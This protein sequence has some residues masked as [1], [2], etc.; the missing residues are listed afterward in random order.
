MRVFIAALAAV[1]GSLALQMS[2]D[3]GYARQFI[4]LIPW[5]W[6]GCA[7]LWTLWLV[8]HDKVAKEWLKNLHDR[9]GKGVYPIRALLCLVVFVGVALVV[10]HWTNKKVES[11]FASGQSSPAQQQP[12]SG[13]QS[14]TVQ[15]NGN[16]TGNVNQGGNNNTAIIG[17]DNAITTYKVTG[18]KLSDW[19]V[20]GKESTPTQRPGCRRPTF[21]YVT[22]LYGDSVSFVPTKGKWFPHTI[23]EIED[24]PKLTVN[25]DKRGR[26]ALSVD[27]YDE[28]GYIVAQ[29]ENNRFTVNRNNYF[30]MTKTSSTLVV[31]DQKNQK[32]IDFRFIN[33]KTIQ[34]DALLYYPELKRP[35]VL[36]KDGNDLSGFRIHGACDTAVAVDVHLSS[37]R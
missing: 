24:K 15:G 17:N 31:I 13:G 26:I 2:I 5:C 1:V 12:I 33:P 36:S 3:A 20:P 35:I 9:L 29:I 16:T 23:I 21:D 30:K 10:G 37:Q 32:V 7:A 4:W 22:L 6:G 28:R 27:I 8:M 11:S 34:I 19:L 14:N 25:K 18:P